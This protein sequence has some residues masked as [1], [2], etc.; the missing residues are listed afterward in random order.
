MTVH[1]AGIDWSH[2][3]PCVSQTAHGLTVFIL[4]LSRL[5][6]FSRVRCL[7]VMRARASSEGKQFPVFDQLTS[8]RSCCFIQLAFGTSSPTGP[9]RAHRWFFLCAFELFSRRFNHYSDQR[10]WQSPWALPGHA[11]TLDKWTSNAS[12]NIPHSVPHHG[13]K[14]WPCFRIYSINRFRHGWFIPFALAPVALRKQFWCRSWG[15]WI[16]AKA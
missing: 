11:G 2:K 3:P 5:M 10:K 13:Y 9:L 14:S 7:Q 4:V 12:N 8:K 1:R 16:W 15:Q 6:L